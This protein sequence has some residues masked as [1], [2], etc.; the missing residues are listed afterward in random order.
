MADDLKTKRT[1]AK[2][3]FTRAERRLKEVVD[4]P[5]S[6]LLSTVVRRFDDMNSR[7][8]AVQEAHDLYVATLPPPLEGETEGAFEEE[9]WIDELMDRFG[10]MEL[11]VDHV[12][13]RLDKP[14]PQAQTQEDVKEV[15][16]VAREVRASGTTAQY[17]VSADSAHLPAGDA[18]GAATTMTTQSTTIPVVS[19]RTNTSMQSMGI[20]TTDHPLQICSPVSLQLE[21]IKIE[22]FNGDMRKYPQF[23]EQFELYVK[24]L[25]ATVQ[26]PLILRSHLEIEIREEVENVEDNMEALWR[27]LDLKYGNRSKYVDIILADIAKAPRG[28]GKTTLQLIKTVERAH[29]DLERIQAAEEMHNGT[30]ISMIEKKLPEEM[31]SGWIR[32]IASRTHERSSDR[33]HTLLQFMGEWRTM[34][35]YDDAAIRRPSDRKGIVHHAMSPEHKPE[36]C[37]IHTDSGGHPIWACKVFKG[38]SVQDRLTI[39]I[40]N[41]ACQACLEI[42][43]PGATDA[44]SCQKRFRC[45]VNGC[46]EAH[47][48]LLH[49]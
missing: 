46:N 27:R 32:E 3:Q 14:K 10:V 13:E 45:P 48:K 34:I 35:E 16:A 12:I 22:K 44:H 8:N 37:W 15:G 9:A 11:K 23:R 20:P 42:K 19:V 6:M 47:N 24:P 39:V 5:D 41:N 28:D 18:R 7:W 1:T 29:R 30:I 2:A 33:F 40:Q 38:K 43:C 26:L 25:C 17:A 4:N 49:Q 36:S 21:R 31:R